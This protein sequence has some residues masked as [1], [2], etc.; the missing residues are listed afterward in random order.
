MVDG[1]RR[2]ERAPLIHRSTSLRPIYSK[3]DETEGVISTLR[4]SCIVASIG[5]LIFLQGTAFV[6][7]ILGGLLLL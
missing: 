7:S 4:G 6:L 2:A 1:L 5:L 3:D